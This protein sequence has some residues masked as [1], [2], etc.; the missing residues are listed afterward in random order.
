MKIIDLSLPIDDKAFEVHK[1][2]IERV[3]HKAG[4][5]KF[6]RVIMGKTLSGKIKYLLGKRILKKEDLPDEE[7]LSL[8]VVHSPVHI[9][10]H[11]DYSFH[12]GSKSENR[13]AKTAEEIPLE[14]CYQDGVRLDFTHKKPNETILA[15][16]IE[17]AV[18]GELFNIIIGS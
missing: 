1:V 10:T 3:T 8:E 7:F 12:Y 18:N 13:P 11:L 14:Y 17:K 5:E 9:G 2:S 4:V 16:E 6:N 15:T